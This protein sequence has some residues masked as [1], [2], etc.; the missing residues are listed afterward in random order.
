MIPKKIH[1]VWIGDKKKPTLLHICVNSW[2][3]KL[4]DY[5]SIAW[6]NNRVLG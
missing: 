2:K 6:N 5:E 3:E 4:P 1:Y